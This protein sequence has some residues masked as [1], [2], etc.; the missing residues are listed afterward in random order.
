MVCPVTRRYGLAAPAILADS[1]KERGMTTPPRRHN[2]GPSSG[3]RP[4]L[5]RLVQ[6]S[7][8]PDGI[9]ALASADGQTII[10]RA[11]LD[12]ATR[13]RAVRQVLGH[14]FP[15]LLVFPVLAGAQL[16]RAL[17][18]AA[19]GASRLMQSAA[20]LITPDSPVFVL[21][22][23]AAV[24]TAS[25]AG[26]AAVA[27]TGG[28]A[29]GG[30]APVPAS[31]PHHPGSPAGQVAALTGHGSRSGSGSGRQ[32]GSPGPA[33]SPGPGTAPVPSPSGSQ[34]TQPLAPIT[35]PVGSLLHSIL[36]TSLP[37][38][39]VPS[40]SVTASLP[41]VPLPSLPPVVP[42]LPS[43]SPTCIKVGPLG[44]CVDP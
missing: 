19:Q 29:H 39:P 35:S 27:L 18:A 16:R 1:G 14:R 43:P 37:P 7:D 24:V 25:A 9:N 10:V 32:P 23:G 26:G 28:G 17:V 41:P 8:L 38:L 13:R 36:P 3:R 2:A 4:A 12:P 21:V 5:V 42:P 40:V 44:V 15:G 11:G 20:G 6:T 30:S 33:P 31:A 22:A 34:P